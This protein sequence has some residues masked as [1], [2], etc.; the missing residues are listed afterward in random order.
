VRVFG[1]LHIVMPENQEQFRSHDQ[2]TSSYVEKNLANEVERILGKNVDANTIQTAIDDY[3]QGWVERSEHDDVA[4]AVA[5]AIQERERN[6]H[7]RSG[8]WDERRDP[9]PFADIASKSISDLRWRDIKDTIEQYD[10]YKQNGHEV[11]ESR[12]LINLVKVAVTNNDPHVPYIGSLPTVVETWIRKKKREA[13]E[14]GYNIHGTLDEQI[15][16]LDTISLSTLKTC[17][18]QAT[19]LTDKKKDEIR[20]A[21]DREY[22]HNIENDSDTISFDHPYIVNNAQLRGSLRYIIQQYKQS[23]ENQSH[24]SHT[25]TDD[26]TK[27]QEDSTA[28]S[29]DTIDNGIEQPTRSVYTQLPEDVIAKL[30]RERD[31][32][33][34]TDPR[35]NEID[36]EIRRIQAT[37]NKVYNTGKNQSHDSHTVTDDDT[38]QQEDSTASSHDVVDYPNASKMFE[39]S[40]ASSKKKT[41]KPLRSAR[42]K[43]F[44]RAYGNESL[45]RHR[46][47]ID[48]VIIGESQANTFETPNNSDNPDT[49]NNPNS[50]DLD[51]H[52]ASSIFNEPEVP[53]NLDSDE[54]N[55]P[56]NSDTS[57]TTFQDSKSSEGTHSPKKSPSAPD[58][59]EPVPESE[60]G[61]EDSEYISQSISNSEHVKENKEQVLHSLHQIGEK[62]GLSSE[63]IK[64]AEIYIILLA[65]EAP[66]RLERIKKEHER[67]TQSENRVRDREQDMPELKN[68]LN[69]K[70]EMLEL[71]QGSGLM[72]PL[73]AGISRV[74]KKIFGGH[75][76][77]VAEKQLNA[78]W[79]ARHVYGIGKGYWRLRK[80]RINSEL[81]LVN[82][83]IELLSQSASLELDKKKHSKE[84]ILSTLQQ[85]RSEV[86]SSL[87]RIQ[88]IRDSGKNHLISFIKNPAR[89][90]RDTPS[91]DQLEEWQNAFDQ[92]TGINAELARKGVHSLL[93]KRVHL[94]L[95]EIIRQTEPQDRLFRNGLRRRLYSYLS[96]RG[97]QVSTRR[98]A[99]L[100]EFFVNTLETFKNADWIESDPDRNAKKII[101]EQVISNLRD[102]S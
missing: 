31:G 49:P 96:D 6:Q 28:S 35:Y 74:K 30:S 54:L 81:H 82:E 47:F 73:I 71:A 68:K 53:N 78:R 67:Y 69:Q 66:Y 72:T 87:K 59:I 22:K 84:Q 32:L 16:D 9:D 89:L 45:P 27:Q 7:E 38:K 55:T 25:V 44:E 91:I 63:Q 39:T 93:Q 40:D 34:K 24:D 92:P 75:T 90:R 99:H 98:S 42:D 2:N 48:D 60:E 23:V 15:Y 20:N 97:E 64:Q 19:N 70:K 77:S 62:I 65:K 50:N 88:Q 61:A 102:S 100:N 52:N 51:V 13:G 80:Q 95:E 4:S 36:R 29:H 46:E 79:E 11:I 17:V 86:T 26:D 10:V 5:D 3:R 94:D 76:E 21:I 101:L 33:K 37:K 85:Q 58:S 18:E 41:S 1:I 12:D 83:Q 14:G 57:N 56:N 8:V 43:A